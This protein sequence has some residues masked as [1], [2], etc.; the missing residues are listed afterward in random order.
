[1]TKIVYVKTDLASLIVTLIGVLKEMLDDVTIEFIKADTDKKGKNKNTEDDPKSPFSGMRILAMSAEKTVLV[2]LKLRAEDFTEFKC[3]NKTYD[4]GVNMTNLYKLLKSTDKEDDLEMYIDSDDEQSLVLSVSS[5][6]CSKTSD[7]EL[8]LLDLDSSA[9]TLPPVEFDVDITM[10][11]CEFHKMCKDM[12]QIGPYLEIKCTA[13]TLYF[14]CIGENS[15]KK[16]KHTTSENGVKIVFSVPDKRVIIQGFYELKCLNLFAK[17][18]NLCGDVRLFMKVKKY[19]LCL[20]YTVGRLGIFMAFVTP[21]APQQK[22]ADDQTDA[23][24]QS[25]EE[26]K[27]KQPDEHNEEPVEKKDIP[28]DSSD[29]SDSS[30]EKE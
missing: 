30:D 14:T 2:C 3:K 19:P 13:N 23:Y 1:M 22:P 4:I 21:I 27:E 15:R 17:C 25:D 26:G 24:Y 8:K 16:I 9:V 7:V 10:N 29:D 28:E 20:Q 18:A 6:D 11:A 5:S 12:S